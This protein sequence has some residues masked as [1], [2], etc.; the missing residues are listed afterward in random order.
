LL[1]VPT[2]LFGGSVD[3]ALDVD[4]HEVDQH[5]AGILLKERCDPFE[6]KPRPSSGIDE[7]EQNALPP[8][9][10]NARMAGMLSSRRAVDSLHLRVLI[11]SANAR[12]FL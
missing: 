11:L 8:S 10:T 9:F 6:R 5:L 3:E 2:L 4:S 7:E 12:S 1:E